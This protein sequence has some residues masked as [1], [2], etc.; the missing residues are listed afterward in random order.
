MSCSHR[1]STCAQ[2]RE[3]NDEEA[4]KDTLSD[5]VAWL[6]GLDED[7]IHDVGLSA[8]TEIADQLESGAWLRHGEEP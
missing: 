5:V 1:P 8:V 3:C 2:C 6:R 7:W 4:R